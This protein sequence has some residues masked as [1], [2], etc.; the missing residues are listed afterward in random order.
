MDRTCEAFL[1]ARV[2]VLVCMS[3]LQ[4][5]AQ[6]TVLSVLGAV[7]KGTALMHWVIIGLFA[8]F[9]LRFFSGPS[10]SPLAMNSSIVIAVL[11]RFTDSKPQF[12]P[13]PPKQFASM[14]GM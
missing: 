6:V 7:F 10:L 9:T 1:C 11:E 12:S 14:C 8:D 2:F 3:M 13:G 4:T 5:G